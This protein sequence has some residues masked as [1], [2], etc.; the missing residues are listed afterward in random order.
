M[1]DGLLR[2]G[3]PELFD[4]VSFDAAAFYRSYVAS[5]LERD[6]RQLLSVGRLRDFERFV[7]ACALRSGQVLN[8]SDLAHDVGVSASTANEWLSVLVASNQVTLLEP[9][10]SNKTKLLTKSPKLY[11][12]DSGLL[13]FLLNIFSED[14]LRRSPLV[15][16][17]WETFVFCEVH[18]RLEQ[19]QE[20]GSLYFWQD[21]SS[22]VDF[23][24]HRGGRFRLWDAKWTELPR[25]DDGASLRAVAAQLGVERVDHMGLICRAPSRFP[26][27]NGLMA[28]TVVSVVEAL[29]GA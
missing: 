14:D 5:Y 16:A 11:V 2:G 4:D 20:A 17:I 7:R 28:D 8:K 25:T 19:S 1:V 29:G 9:W 3:F 10:F 18:K 21:R 6:V 22:E 15:G 13:C 24:Y 12:R 27:G 23:V 26:L